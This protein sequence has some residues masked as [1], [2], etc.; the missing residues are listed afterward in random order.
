MQIIGS[1]LIKL[2]KYKYTQSLPFHFATIK[3][4]KFHSIFLS[5]AYISVLIISTSINSPETITILNRMENYTQ[6]KTLLIDVTG[7][8]FNKRN[9]FFRQP[10]NADRQTKNQNYT[11]SHL[12]VLTILTEKLK[13]FLNNSL[14]SDFLKVFNQ[15]ERDNNMMMVDEKPPTTH[16]SVPPSSSARQS[17]QFS[18]RQ[19]RYDNGFDDAI[20]ELIRNYTAAIQ[21]NSKINLS[22]LLS[23]AQV[24][25]AA[26]SNGNGSR[27]SSS[28]VVAKL[29]QS[30]VDMCAGKRCE[31]SINSDI[32]ICENI[33]KSNRS[34]ANEVIKS[35]CEQLTAT[36]HN[37]NNRSRNGAPLLNV[38]HTKNR[39]RNAAG[40][41]Q[42]N[43]QQPPSPV[44]FGE[45]FSLFDFIAATM[46]NDAT[47]NGFNTTSSTAANGS[48]PIKFDFIVLD[49]HTIV[50]NRSIET[51]EWRPYLV[52]QQNQ[53]NQRLFTT[54]HVM[55][56]VTTS[57]D[58]ND[59]ILSQ[60]NM[61]WSCG[62][63][64]W[65]ITTFAM[66]IFIF[67]IVASVAVGI[68]VR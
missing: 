24:R 20:I 38:R 17:L 26:A 21:Q 36:N 54:H 7:A 16:V 27:S 35:V 42:L 43:E 11:K 22:T 59:W 55:S 44:S 67:S 39:K 49:F 66:V 62:A 30:L 48:I 41:E 2:H 57:S 9:D 34:I 1:K 58:Y 18:G 32:S 19:K 15:S 29:E 33:F 12:F 68:S 50:A 47:N 65:S 25:T 61:W 5:A 37:A 10:I 63:Q 14:N 52:L 8:I 23:S 56:D 3:L 40:Y 28:V 31:N 13:Q 4:I 46:L 45:F 6:T 53:I 64:C 60:T 51:I